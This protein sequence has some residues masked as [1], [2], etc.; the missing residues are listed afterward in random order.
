MKKREQERVKKIRLFSFL[1]SSAE[2]FLV[3]EFPQ[4]LLSDLPNLDVGLQEKS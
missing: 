3:F 2:S 1:P 4:S